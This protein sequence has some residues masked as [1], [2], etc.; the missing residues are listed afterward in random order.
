MPSPAF[1]YTVF[2]STHA[3]REEGDVSST[4]VPE[5]IND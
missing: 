5:V 4:L 3:L 1:L 2:I